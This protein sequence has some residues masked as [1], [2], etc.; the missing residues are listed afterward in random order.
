MKKINPK[1]WDLNNVINFLW[2]VQYELFL[3]Q[4]FP[5]IRLRSCGTTK[6]LSYERLALQEGPCILLWKLHAS[7]RAFLHPIS[8]SGSH[9]RLEFPSLMLCVSVFPVLRRLG[10]SKAPCLQTPP[11]TAQQSSVQCSEQWP[12]LLTA[13]GE[14]LESKLSR[15]APHFCKAAHALVNLPVSFLKRCSKIVLILI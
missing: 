9:E 6:I 10:A 11:N 13:V 3:T 5:P 7:F 8:L 4:F 1:A 12:R 14:M 15:R 2:Q